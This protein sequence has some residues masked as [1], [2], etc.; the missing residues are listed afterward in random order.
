MREFPVSYITSNK[1]ADYYAV[2]AAKQITVS[3]RNNG[4][5]LCHTCRAN[6]CEHTPSVEAYAKENSTTERTQ[7]MRDRAELI[8]KGEITEPA[9]VLDLSEVEL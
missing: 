1:L 8:E 5:L 4:K 9:T 7:W 2:G 3:I 6:K